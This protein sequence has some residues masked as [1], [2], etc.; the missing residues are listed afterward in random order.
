QF[1]RQ[2]VY[3][4]PVTCAL[5][6]T[7]ASL[8]HSLHPAYTTDESLLRTFKICEARSR[9]ELLMAAPC[10]DRPHRRFVSIHRKDALPDLAWRSL[11][12]PLARQRP[13]EQSLPWWRDNCS[14][15]FSCHL[16]PPSE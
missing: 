14:L 2:E 5:S 12:R 10:S 4:M 13:P 11:R 16:P 9:R 15:G 1:M 7:Q 8:E 3:A 6:R